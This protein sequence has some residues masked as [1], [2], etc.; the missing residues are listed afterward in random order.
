MIG[1]SNRHTVPMTQATTYN[2]AVCTDCIMMIANG[3]GGSHLVMSMMAEWP[4][5]L[6]GYGGDPDDEADFSG[7]PC[8]G[9]GSQLGGARH[10][11]HA[12]AR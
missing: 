4:D 12:F 5:H 3:E 8:E 1:P 2:I 9:C 7:T 6:L 11:A 10:A